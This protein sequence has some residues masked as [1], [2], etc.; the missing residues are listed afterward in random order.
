[1]NERKMRPSACSGDAGASKES[2]PFCH[3]VMLAMNAM[4]VSSDA[5]VSASGSDGGLLSENFGAP[6]PIHQ[7]KQWANVGR[8]VPAAD[9]CL[10]IRVQRGFLGA[11]VDARHDEERARIA[12]RCAAL[13]RGRDGVEV[14]GVTQQRRNDDEP[15]RSLSG[16]A[17][18]ERVGAA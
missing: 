9:P 1:M 5:P 18:A 2:L 7:L 6:R 17:L 16:G 3:D 4:Q 14:V 8:V 12:V 13:E 10:E 11:S 15:G